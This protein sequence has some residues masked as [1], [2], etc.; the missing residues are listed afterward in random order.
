MNSYQEIDGLVVRYQAGDKAAGELLV[1]AF[2][3]LVL[4]TMA[5]V[6]VPPQD[7]EDAFQ[8]GIVAFMEGVHRFSPDHGAGF[9]AFIKT[10]LWHYY[11]K[12]QSGQFNRSLEAEERLDA[13]FGR[14]GLTLQETIKDEGES[15]ENMLSEEVTT[16]VKRQA[17]KNGL[18]QLTKKQ[19]SV[20][21]DH[22]FK[23]MTLREMGRERHISHEAVRVCLGAALKKLK[24]FF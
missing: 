1:M 4:S 23:G 2:K 8:D 21:Y 17:L 18:S 10:H 5:K 11:L 16:A 22:Y 12:R 9:N 14:D 15:I 7:Q 19:K 6:Y 3:P 13:A 24:K 20:I